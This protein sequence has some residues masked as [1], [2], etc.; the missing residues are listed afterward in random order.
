[1]ASSYA[2]HMGSLSVYTRVHVPAIPHPPQDWYFQVFKTEPFYLM[3]GGIS[4]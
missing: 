4:L 1:M 2:V 3:C